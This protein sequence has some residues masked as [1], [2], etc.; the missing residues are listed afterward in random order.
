MIDNLYD[1]ENESQDQKKQKLFQGLTMIGKSKNHKKPTIINESNFIDNKI[2]IE[3]ST[4]LGF[5]NEILIF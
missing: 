5:Y 2:Q 1:I 3:L 4:K